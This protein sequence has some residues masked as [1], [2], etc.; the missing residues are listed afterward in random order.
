MPRLPFRIA[1]FLSSYA[2]LFALLAVTNRT[3]ARAWHALVAI[4]VVSVLSLV[5]VMWSK[6]DETG[7]RLTVANVKPK[8]GDVMAY[9]ATYLLPFLA[10]DVTKLDG[11]VLLAGFM[12]VLGT[13]Y[14][15]SNMIF[16]NPL[17]SLVG[18]HT[19]EVTDPDDHEYALLTRRRELAAGTAIKPAQVTAYI[20][21][22]VRRQP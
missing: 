11:V 2:P 13:V 6:K 10:V 3:C 9:V 18:Y 12:L 14:V 7:Q 21:V 8:D 19:F 4:A 20:R 15:N 16:V 5:V 22:E 17:L 1:L